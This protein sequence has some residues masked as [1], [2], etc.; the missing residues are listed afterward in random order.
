MPL[1]LN[2]LAGA[3]LSALIAAVILIPLARLI[4]LKLEEQ[5]RAELL[6]SSELFSQP[7]NPAQFSLAWMDKLLLLMATS[8]TAFLVLSYKGIDMASIA[9]CIYLFA[10]LLL[11]AINLKHQL[12][13]DIIV[14][15]V[16]WLGLLYH[17][18]LGNSSEYVIGGCIGYLAPYALLVLVKILTGNI[19]IGH[20]DL[21]CFAMAGAWL[22]AA[23][24]PTVFSVFVASV[25]IVMVVA[26]LARFKGPLPSGPSHLA[27]S[28]AV[29]MGLSIY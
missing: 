9:L 13:P 25:F 8:A 12:L 21:K 2:T 26:A 24:L 6:E 18:I 1:E 10:L 14:L 17:A 20:G 7:L 16:L 19:V 22:G 4:P 28:I 15:S 11:V 3:A 29:L 23:A 27:A 5:W